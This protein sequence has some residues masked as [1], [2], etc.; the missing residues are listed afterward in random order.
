MTA[1][2]RFEL[3]LPSHPGRSSD[4]LRRQAGATLEATSLQDGPAIGRRHTVSEPMLL[5]STT[6]VGLKCALHSV[7][8]GEFEKPVQATIVTSITQ[9]SDEIEPG[10]ARGFLS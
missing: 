9:Q 2:D 10:K 5:G 3:N 7:S 8:F 1:G 4:D 6:V